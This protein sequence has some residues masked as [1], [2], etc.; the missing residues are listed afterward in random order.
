MI[1]GVNLGMSGHGDQKG[2]FMVVV[3][4]VSLVSNGGTY[5]LAFHYSCSITT[6]KKTSAT[7]RR[8]FTRRGS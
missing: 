2:K 6:K 7:K 4:V 8:I 5:E 3:V 1:D